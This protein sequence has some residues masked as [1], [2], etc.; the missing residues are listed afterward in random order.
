MQLC[1]TLSTWPGHVMSGVDVGWTEG[2]LHL[3][4]YRSIFLQAGVRPSSDGAVSDVIHTPPSN[5]SPT[6]CESAQ[7]LIGSQSWTSEKFFGLSI[8]YLGEEWT[9]VWPSLGTWP[10]SLWNPHFS[11][12]ISWVPELYLTSVALRTKHQASLHGKQTVHQ[13]N[14]TPTL[15][16]FVVCDRESHSVA[17]ADLNLSV[18]LIW[19]VPFMRVRLTG[20]LVEMNAEMRE[21]KEPIQRN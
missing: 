12:S 8:S 21:M 19:T 11:A 2:R 6:P 3:C 13:L 16:F 20:Q 18:F 17:Q 10:G 15:A 9:F 1:V 5:C 14:Y 7:C 4:S